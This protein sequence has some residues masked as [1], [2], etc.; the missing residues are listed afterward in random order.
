LV[1]TLALLNGILYCCVLP[2]WEGFDEPFHYAYVQAISQ[3]HALP[4]LNRM[5]ISL[6][7]RRSLNA[8]PLSRLLSETVPGSI[9]FEEWSK[10]TEQEK[11]SRF[12]QLRELT[13]QMQKES[14]GIL[15]YEAQQAPL[16]YVL[17]SP[18]DWAVAGAPLR[19]R[20]IWL[21][22]IGTVASSV[23]LFFGLERLSRVL[24]LNGVLRLSCF[25]VCFEVQMLW[26]SIAHVGNDV[27]AIPLTVWFLAMLTIAVKRSTARNLLVVSL[28]FALGLLSKAYFLAFAPLMAGL[29]IWLS[30]TRRVTWKA[31]GLSAALIFLINAPWYARNYALYG[32]FSGTQQSVAGV[33]FRQAMAALSEIHWPR[34][35][36]DFALWSLWT[37]NWSFLA[38][39]KATLF[40]ELL[41]LSGAL[42]CYL[43]HMPRIER[44]ELWLLGGCVLF[45]LGLVYQT[46][47]TWVATHGESTHAEPWYAQG[48]LSVLI[49]LAFRGVSLSGRVGRMIVVPLL[50]VAAWIAAVTYPIK[51]LP[52]YGSAITRSTLA[53]V[54]AWWQAHPTADLNMVTLA[55]VS[56]IYVGLACFLV[57]LVATNYWL[58]QSLLDL[59]NSDSSVPSSKQPSTLR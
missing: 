22:I 55:P 38:F 54:W 51:L 24:E 1:L 4:V 56:L 15:N 6:E 11:K 19:S 49:V 20:I 2:L 30:A 29:M 23:F 46:C 37:G 21:R 32:S 28:I 39:S 40:L 47:V 34:S 31:A 12:D 48:L 10:L 59:S 43:L 58:M 33:G 13:S 35:A 8:V 50:L 57:L 26:A 3:L 7:I 41:L 18:L 25:T 44:G 5:T 52:Y 16:A 9:S 27:L 36:L 45:A 42:I 53:R 14:G 17:Y